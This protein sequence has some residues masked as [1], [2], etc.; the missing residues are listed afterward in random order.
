M[1]EELSYLRESEPYCYPSK[2][3]LAASCKLCEEAGIR[4]EQE[5]IQAGR[6]KAQVEALAL[7]HLP[8]LA[9]ARIVRQCSPSARR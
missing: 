9:R 4:R 5:R 8:L 7:A 1:W 2:E 6:S 3:R